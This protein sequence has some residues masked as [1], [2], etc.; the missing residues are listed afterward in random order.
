MDCKFGMSAQDKRMEAMVLLQLGYGFTLKQSLKLLYFWN[1]FVVG[2][3]RRV[4]FVL[5][6]EDVGMEP[7]ARR[8]CQ[9][10][11]WCWRCS[12]DLSNVAVLT[13]SK[14]WRPCWCVSAAE[15]W[16][17]TFKAKVIKHAIHMQS[18]LDSS[19]PILGRPSGVSS[20]PI[21][22]GRTCGRRGLSLQKRWGISGNRTTSLPRQDTGHGQDMTASFSSKPRR[23]T[24]KQETMIT[25]AKLSKQKVW[26]V[27]QN[28]H[29]ILRLKPFA[30]SSSCMWR[31]TRVEE[32]LTAAKRGITVC[33]ELGDAAAQVR[34]RS[35]EP[36]QSDEDWWRL[37]KIDEDRVNVSL[38]S[39]PP[40]PGCFHCHRCLPSLPSIPE[41]YRCHTGLDPGMMPLGCHWF[42]GPGFP[43]AHSWTCSLADGTAGQGHRHCARMRSRCW[44]RS[45]PQQK[46]ICEDKVRYWS[47]NLDLPSFLGCMKLPQSGH[48][49]KVA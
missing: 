24:S 4:C 31:Q 10:S 27:S 28:C 1:I 39:L 36:K 41:K 37:G 26:Q 45:L 7:E 5:R 19:P 12:G 46:R 35:R 18:F 6:K 42:F 49:E 13:R 34:L 47:T 14:G 15:V 43:D 44:R 3:L 17:F 38:L 48:A 8:S 23:N 22:H 32:A 33:K 30:C 2:R 20:M 16:H 9:S 25:M 11:F 21:W 29:Q 40:S